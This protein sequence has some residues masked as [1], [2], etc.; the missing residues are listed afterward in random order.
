MVL[1]RIYSRHFPF[2]GYTAMTLC[3]WIFI[4]EDLKYKYN[5]TVDRHETTHAFQQLETLWVFFLII[6]C[7][8]Y[9]IK[10][11]ITFSHERAYKSI[12]FEQEAYDHE[13]ETYYNDVRKG[14][15]WVKYIFK[16]VEE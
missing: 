7:L 13:D 1:K 16:I 4:S 8:E 6:Y 12:S 2:K 9:L 3:P 15:A 5:D 11:L 10:L 14:F